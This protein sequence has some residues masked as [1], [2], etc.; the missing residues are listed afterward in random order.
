MKFLTTCVLL[1]LMMLAWSCDETDDG[2]ASI[3]KLRFESGTFDQSKPTIIF[4]GGGNCVNSWD[5]TESWVNEETN[6]EAWF[7]KVNVISFHSYRKDND[8]RDTTYFDAA[9]LVVDSILALAPEYNKPVQVCGFSTGGT[10]AL[11]L[12]I[13]SNIKG[14]N[15]PFR[16]SNVTLMDAPC[17]DYKERIRSL[18]SLINPPL[19]VNLMGSLFDDR[20]PYVG[21]LN[22]DVMEGHDEVFWWY[23]NSLTMDN[24][25]SFNGGV[26]G[27]AYLSVIGEGRDFRISTKTDQVEYYFDW[28]G[29]MDQGS[30][31]FLDAS[32]YPSRLSGPMISVGGPFS[33]DDLGTTLIHEHIL[34]D[35]I[36][37]D[38]TAYHRWDKRKVVD[39]M[40]PY[41]LE[42]KE[43]GVNTLLECTP[44]YL[45][46]DPIIMKTLEERS[47]VRIL[48][49]TG[50]YGAVNDKYLPPHAFSE[51]IDELAA[52]WI[53]EFEN[54]IEDT[55]IRPGFIK[56]S[57]DPDAKLS[58]VDEKIVRAA[59][60]TH[61]ATG[62]TIVAHTGPD[63]TA[64][65]ELE[66][67]EEEGVHPSAWVWTHASEG[68]NQ[69]RV[70]AARMGAWISIDDVDVENVTEI[71][72]RLEVLKK[73]GLIGRVLISHD[74]GW[75][76]PDEPENDDI[77][78][79]TDIFDHLI[80]ELISRGF[81][82][83]D[84]DQLLINNPRE[85]YT[86][87]LRMN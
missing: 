84:V 22:V 27:G 18:N 67:L 58:E 70:R 86:I 13:Y 33:P 72:D 37:A 62:L 44:A 87:R 52:R 24:G 48:I 1:V 51:T 73:N 68:T 25:N 2:V 6:G 60:L 38:K 28:K 78:G 19:I 42:A 43:K 11:D 61:K 40:L 16:V 75:Y 3:N 49:N 65:A 47:G 56:I 21:A 23:V 7:N 35:F 77:K 71:A 54:G 29:D 12:A 85:A 36:G 63:Q 69:G 46:R 53:A 34:V 64:F 20:P 66:I 15:I 79:Y 10:P 45:G 80:P 31:D 17:Y 30:F 83:L 39:K 4:F 41:L 81:S 8:T 76:D 14:M 55:G 50:Y 5:G 26:T 82:D 9:K 74:A 59:A 32:T 57:V